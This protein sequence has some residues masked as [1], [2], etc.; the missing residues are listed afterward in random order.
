MKYIKKKFADEDG[1]PVSFWS[2]DDNV[3][4]EDGKTLRENLNN[5]DAQCK[6]IANN[7]SSIKNDIQVQTARI[8]NLTAL[9]DGSTTGDAELIDGRVGANGITYDSIGTSIRE[10][11]KNI[12][13][14]IPLSYTL[15]Q[16]GKYK[17][18]RHISSRCAEML[19][20]CLLPAL[21]LHLSL[22]AVEWKCCF[23]TCCLTFNISCVR[24]YI[25]IYPS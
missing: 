13:N 7:N 4:C 21:I 6:D 9:Q 20:C 2:T 11:I 5:I 15:L 25:G 14:T 16:S 12:Y 10:Q 22:K 19:P 3:L 23:V 18:V 17:I 1:V 8:D 24:I